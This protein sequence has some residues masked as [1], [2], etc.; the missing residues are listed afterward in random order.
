MRACVAAFLV[1][2]R[3][4]RF[5]LA[6]A[7]AMFFK[8]R[9]NRLLMYSGPNHEIPWEE[10][11]GTADFASHFRF[12]NLADLKRLASALDW[13][14]VVITRPT[15]AGTCYTVDGLSAL[16][17]VLKRLVF[18]GRIVDILRLFR[19]SWSPAKL[20]RV[21][22]TSLLWLHDRFA[23]KIH[24]DEKALRDPV[25]HEI[26]LAAIVAQGGRLFGP[27]GQ[28]YRNII[29]FVDGTEFGISRPGQEE[30]AF[31]SGWKRHHCLRYQ[32][33]MMPD[34]VLYSF[35][36]PFR[37]ESAA[38]TDAAPSLAL[39]VVAPETSAQTCAPSVVLIHHHSV[40]RR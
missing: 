3:W 2:R 37:G 31:Y 15:V 24:F 33:I 35:Y 7:T 4:N 32:G 19:L 9:V 26:W 5:E 38:L 10:F 23:S 40:N 13:P 6:L 17:V 20:S 14:D 12:A 39:A 36:G 1:Y 18:P 30:N 16:G 25:T 28:Y 34:G 8:D 22:M 27:N 21:V 11:E 29:G